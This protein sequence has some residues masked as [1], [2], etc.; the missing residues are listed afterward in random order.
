ML[1][2]MLR[3]IS[4]KR[5]GGANTPIDD[6][7]GSIEEWQ[8]MARRRGTQCLILMVT[9]LSM[10][11]GFTFSWIFPP[12]VRYLGGSA[13]AA[14]VIGATSFCLGLMV[15]AVLFV[16]LLQM[17]PLRPPMESIFTCKKCKAA[18]PIDVSKILRMT[19]FKCKVCGHTV[20]LSGSKELKKMSR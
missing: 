12:L 11:F 6:W 15:T 1:F 4:K 2:I 18:Y 14:Q 16:G 3:F 10:Y 5:G 9:L 8:Y 17:L 13:K 20:P 7:N 19:Q